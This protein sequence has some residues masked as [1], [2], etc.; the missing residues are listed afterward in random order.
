MPPRGGP[1][2]DQLLHDLNTDFFQPLVSG[3]SQLFGG[4][5]PPPRS[6]PASGAPFPG[7]ARRDGRPTSRPTPTAPRQQWG[8]PRQQPGARESSSAVPPFPKMRITADEASHVENCAICLED[9]REG[10]EA[11]LT[12]CYHIFHSACLTDWWWRNA[13]C[14]LCKAE[15]MTGQQGRAL[16][17]RKQREWVEE[18]AAGMRRKRVGEMTNKEIKQRLSDL[19]VSTKGVLERSELVELLLCYDP[20]MGVRVS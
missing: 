13:T 18:R 19:K 17:E 1:Q 20:S 9:L 7:Q 5:P 4:S 8:Q 6:S 14:P 15:S 16:R 10:D 11:Y 2:V 3:V 12:D